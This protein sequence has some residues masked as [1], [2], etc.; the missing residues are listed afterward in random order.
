MTPLGYASYLIYKNGAFTHPATKCALG[1]YGCSMLLSAV[2]VYLYETRNLSALAK[3]KT[4]LFLTSLA[5]SVAFYKIDQTAGLLFSI[6]TAMS[7][8]CAFSYCVMCKC[9]HK[10]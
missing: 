8:G 2:N 10:D 3:N 9:E 5:T 6:F 4:L 7:A 1:L